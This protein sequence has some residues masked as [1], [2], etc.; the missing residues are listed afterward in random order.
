[1]L[2]LGGVGDRPQGEGEVHVQCTKILD[3]IFKVISI[4][5]H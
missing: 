3:M 2:L 4:N 5:I 1:M